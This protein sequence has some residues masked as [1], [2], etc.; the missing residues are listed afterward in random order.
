[1]YMIQKVLAALVLPFMIMSQA[2]GDDAAQTRGQ[3]PLQA[4]DSNASVIK[5]AANGVTLDQGQPDHPKVQAPQADKVVFVVS[6][7]AVPSTMEKI[8]F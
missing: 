4:G 7:S 2:V 8:S 5:S 3:M 1:M 6:A